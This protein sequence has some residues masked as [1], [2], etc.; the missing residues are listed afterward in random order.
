MK[1]NFDFDS[2]SGCGAAVL[3][4]R[5][6]DRLH[7]REK[8]HNNA[9]ADR[10]TKGASMVI[11][12]KR[13]ASTPHGRRASSL[14]D[15]DPLVGAQSELA[16][17]YGAVSVLYGPEAAMQAASD[18]VEELERS[19]RLGGGSQEDWRRMTIVAADNLA[20]RVVDRRANQ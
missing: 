9:S 6:I 8:R 1:C 19:N 12:D 11:C 10:G 16:A 13:A 4:H 2:E 14:A 15:S 17:F 7:R 3:F 20:S 5:W 18:W